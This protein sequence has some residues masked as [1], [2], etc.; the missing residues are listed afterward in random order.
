MTEDQAWHDI[1]ADLDETRIEGE[2]IIARRPKGGERIWTTAGEDDDEVIP[3]DVKP[4][5]AVWFDTGAGI[6]HAWIEDGSM[7]FVGGD[8]SDEVTL[9]P[10]SENEIRVAVVR[11]TRG[12][13]T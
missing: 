11:S 1:M 7:V 4:D 10:L 12:S 2:A 9:T 3:L 13:M 8:L 5:R 6:I